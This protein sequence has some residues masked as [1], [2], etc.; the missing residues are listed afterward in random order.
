MNLKSDLLSL[1]FVI[2]ILGGF[3]SPLRADEPVRELMQVSAVADDGTL[4]INVDH[5]RAK[6]ESYARMAHG[7]R[8][9]FI[10]G[11]GSKD[12]AQPFEKAGRC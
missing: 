2:A 5:F 8:A 6:A 3:Y 12:R 10:F 7:R 4:E 9:T 11:S 1:A